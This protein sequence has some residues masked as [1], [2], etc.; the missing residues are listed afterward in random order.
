MANLIIK[1]DGLGDLI[2]V[3]GLIRD[4]ASALAP[5][6]LVTSA[7]NREIAEAIPGLAAIHYLS[8]DSLK[9]QR[10]LLRLGIRW[11]R[12]TSA[13][14]DLLSSLGSRKFETAICLRRFIRQSSLRVMSS[15]RAER[16]FCAWQF[17]TNCSRGF[18]ADLSAGWKS[19]DGPVTMRSELEYFRTFIKTVLGHDSR[20]AP[21][22]SIP[23]SSMDQSAS[24][25]VGLAIGGSSTNWPSEYWM[26]TAR[27]LVE[28]GRRVVLFGGP[29]AVQLAGRI[30]SRTPIVANH[31]G[32][33][34]F[35]QAVEPL[36]YLSL[37]IGN[38]TGFT[39][40]ATLYTR[41][42]LVVLGGGTFRRF[43]PWPE[44]SNQHILY[45]GME[46]FDC[47]W[48]CRFNSRRCLDAVAP[49]TVIDFA[50]RI[51]AGGAGLTL[52]INP[53]QTAYR[54]AWRHCPESKSTAV[55]DP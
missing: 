6:E 53:N 31:V 11:D 27:D 4:L 47:D 1:N 26:T 18:A 39:H 38:D 29:D 45:H 40:F 41:Q 13:D 50:E 14:K 20:S 28:R 24:D 23:A 54:L 8:R 34:S 43:F 19:W 2:L 10:H 48:R 49:T 25:L 12:A 35:A 51:L 55:C 22:L 5:L 42:L 32:K 46:C 44:A 9:Y 33:L 16:Q 3:S 36:S 52:D 30:V 7:A 17:P 15:V 21:G 37:L